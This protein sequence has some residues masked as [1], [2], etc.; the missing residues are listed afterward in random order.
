MPSSS[1]EGQQEETSHRVAAHFG[2]TLKTEKMLI[3]VQDNVNYT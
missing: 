2:I 3:A 1:S